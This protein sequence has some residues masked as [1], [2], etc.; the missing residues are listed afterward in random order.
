M[1]RIDVLTTVWSSAD[2]NIPAI[3]PA[4]TS[5]I[6]RFV[7]TGLADAGDTAFMQKLAL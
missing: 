7:M 2:R 4:I 5:M 3:S 1:V 6:W